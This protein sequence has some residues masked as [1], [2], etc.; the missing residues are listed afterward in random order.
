V[1]DCDIVE[2]TK[3][4]EKIFWPCAIDLVLEGGSSA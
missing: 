1:L 2:G 4:C 3:F